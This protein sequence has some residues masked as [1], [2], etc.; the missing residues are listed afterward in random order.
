SSLPEYMVPTAFVFLDALPMTPSGKIDR[1]ALP[2]PDSKRASEGTA[3]VAPRDPSELRLAAIWERIFGVR[4]IGVTD[5]FFDL[6]GHSLLAARLFEEVQKAFGSRLLASS[7]LQAPTIEKLA[8]RLS[9]GEEAAARWTSLV[10]ITPGSRRPPLFCLHAGAGTILFYYDL[11]RELGPDQP[12]YG[13]QAQGL[14]GRHPPH[15]R[16]DEMAAHYLREI[17]GIQPNGPYHLAGFCFGAILA[18]EMAQ[19]LRRQGQEVA[20]LASFDGGRPRYE[21]SRAGLDATLLV[22]DQSALRSIARRVSGHWRNFRRRGPAYLVERVRERAIG[23]ARTLEYSIGRRLADRGRPLPALLRQRFFLRNNWHAEDDYRPRPYDG[24]M[25]VFSTP[26]W[27][28]EPTLGWKELVRGG[29]EVHP[30]AGDHRSHR[31]LMTGKFVTEVAARLR[32][33]LANSSSSTVALSGWTEK[34]DG[35]K[36]TEPT[37]EEAKAG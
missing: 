37:R 29:I 18:F 19:Q 4:P 24:R 3:F 33:S 22:P 7:L 5:D 16:V 30:I 12:V 28:S 23:P 20:L 21:T 17:R 9:G 25:V 13:L 36:H 2:A 1:R 15:R 27:A 8:A 10:P 32:A 11:A 6:G 34:N 31:D 14:Y 26:E 35:Q